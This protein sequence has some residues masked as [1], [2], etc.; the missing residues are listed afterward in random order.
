MTA[1]CRTGYRAI[2]AE[3][4]REFLRRW[5]PGRRLATHAELAERFSTTPVTLQRA[6][7]LLAEQGFIVTRPTV[8]SFLAPRPP[9]TCQVGLAFPGHPEALVKRGWSR[10]Y[11]ANLRAAEELNATQERWVFRFY[12]DTQ[13][14]AASRR[15][16]L[17]DIEDGALAGLIWS[18]SPHDLGEHP[19][20]VEP[21]LPMVHFSANF[22]PEWPG[23]RIRE[24]GHQLFLDTAMQWALQRG[25]Q[26]VATL[27]TSKRDPEELVKA[28][29]VHDLAFHPEWNLPADPYSL[30]WLDGLVA[31]I[32]RPGNRLQPDALIITDDHLV[33]PAIRALLEL[34]PD[35]LNELA[36]FAHWNFPLPYHGG[37]PVTRCGHDAAA[38]LNAAL[39]QL[40]TAIGG[41]APLDSEESR[42]TWRLVDPSG[43]DSHKLRPH[44]L[45]EIIPCPA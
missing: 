26:R 45:K 35:G 8:G 13:S 25:R 22:R 39:E 11:L 6:M 4:R 17:Q 24:N 42:S 30:R 32:F 15:Q 18:Y 9:H 43:N 10:Q 38:W 29:A 31:A 1:T 34:R 19:L 12:M 28:F 20:L 40:D 36:I 3:L 14:D 5:E 23:L 27:N 33:E 2:A 21:P 41:A 7:N 44:H 16:L 37:L